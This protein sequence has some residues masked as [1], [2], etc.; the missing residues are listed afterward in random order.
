MLAACTLGPD[1]LRSAGFL[2]VWIE[3]DGR[4]RILGR[5]DGTSTADYV[6]RIT[7]VAGLDA[8]LEWDGDRVVFWTAT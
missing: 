1:G 2:P 5:G 4:P 6:R 3:D 8:S 7:A